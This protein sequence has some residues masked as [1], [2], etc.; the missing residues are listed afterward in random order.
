MYRESTYFVDGNPFI[1]RPRAIPAI[2]EK[3]KGT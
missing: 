3:I 2:V 1:T